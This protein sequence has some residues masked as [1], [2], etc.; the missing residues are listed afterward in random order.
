MPRVFEIVFFLFSLLGLFGCTTAL[1]PRAEQN[2]FRVAKA[3]ILG[4]IRTVALAPV[5]IPEGLDG[6]EGINLEI[7]SLLEGTLREGGFAPVL[8]KAFGEAWKEAVDR[9]GGYFNPR[10]GEVDETRY[11]EVRTLALRALKDS[12]GA[13]GV[14]FPAIQVVEVEWKGGTVH[15]DG[16]SEHLISPGRQ[17]L[18]TALIIQRTGR[19]SALSLALRLVDIN[20]NEVYLKR[21]GL[22][23]GA[24]WDRSTG[25]S[26]GL[27]DRGR[28]ERAVEIALGPLLGKAVPLRETGAGGAVPSP[29]SQR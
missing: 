16:V 27:T 17:V 22:Q 14:L 5:S 12:C 25:R 18:D 2:P 19:V 24:R 4:R 26:E 29:S 8:P 21:G 1:P 15:W 28:M 23:L 13:D 9:V 6:P 11:R 20:G 3:E 10:S 7:E